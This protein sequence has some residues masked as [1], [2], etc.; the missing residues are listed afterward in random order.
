MYWTNL[1]RRARI[2]EMNV[3]V[4]T[5]SGWVV[6]P[7]NDDSQAGDQPQ[8]P[9]QDMED[10]GWIADGEGD[11]QEVVDEIESLPLPAGYDPKFFMFWEQM[12]PEQQAWENKG[13]KATG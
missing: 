11:F 6:T 3:G 8:Q 12:N 9:P 10:P 1:G 5:R 13:E 2:D 7:T 4:V